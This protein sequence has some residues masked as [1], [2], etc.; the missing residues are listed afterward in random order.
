VPL[1]SAIITEFNNEYVV[2][3]L[4]Q[5][6]IHFHTKKMKKSRHF[7]KYAWFPSDSKEKKPARTLTDLVDLIRKKPDWLQIFYSF[8]ETKL[9]DVSHVACITIFNLI[10]NRWWCPFQFEHLFS[11]LEAEVFDSRDFFLNLNHF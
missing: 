1:V 5:S 6:K 8:H 4:N 3:E 11:I 7:K 10:V 9:F 2:S